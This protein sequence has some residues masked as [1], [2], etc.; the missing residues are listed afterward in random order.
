MKVCRGCGKKV[1]V[2]TGV[3]G[4]SMFIFYVDPGEYR[5]VRDERGVYEFIT[6]SRER[7]RGNLVQY[8]PR[9]ENGRFVHVCEGG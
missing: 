5:F 4:N 9:E 6:P 3:D 2:V 8:H 7:V 1:E